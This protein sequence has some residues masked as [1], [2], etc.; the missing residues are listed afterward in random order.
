[1]KTPKARRESS[2]RASAATNRADAPSI[3]QRDLVSMLN[4]K[5]R[6]AALG[7]AVS[8]INHDL[9]NFASSHC[10]SHQLA[11]V[12]DPRVQRFAPKLMRCW[13]APS[14]FVSRRCLMAAP[15]KRRPTAADSGRAGG[16]R[17]ARV[18]GARVGRVDHLDQRDRAR[19]HRRRRSRS[20]VSRAAQLVQRGA[21]AGEPAPGATAA[22]RRSALPVAA[23]V[24]SRSSRYPTP[25]PACRRMPV[26]ICSRRS[27]PSPAA[28]VQRARAVL[29]ELVR[30][31]DGEIHLVEGTIGATFRLA[32]PTAR[33]NC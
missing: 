9:R 27:R 5:S 22:P 10:C 6:L 23:R 14:P 8:K 15:R 13:S 20:A 28:Q 3:T 19:A 17:G 32:I 29:A 16:C 18:G 31:H 25:A 30:A 21:G 2:C 26:S 11:S 1:M 12:P 24:R 7:L 4:Q 33:W